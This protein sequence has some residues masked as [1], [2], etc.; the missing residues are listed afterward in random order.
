M[1]LLTCEQLIL[2]NADSDWHH[3]LWVNIDSMSESPNMC[4]EKL[5]RKRQQDFPAEEYPTFKM[6]HVVILIVQ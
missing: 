4:E 6:G 1:Q 3:P 2:K 5:K